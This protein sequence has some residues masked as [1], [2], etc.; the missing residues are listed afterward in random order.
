MG[1]AQEKELSSVGESEMLSQTGNFGCRYF[2]CLIFPLQTTTGDFRRQYFACLIF[3][4]KLRF[5]IT[6]GDCHDIRA[7][8]LHVEFNSIELVLKHSTV[9]KTFT[10]CNS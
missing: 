10:M 3:P 4:C 6:L 5:L 2:A 9:K 8:V 1:F 7:A